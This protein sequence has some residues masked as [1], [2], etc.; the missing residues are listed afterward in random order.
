[1]EKLFPNICF[2]HA[3]ESAQLPIIERD[4]G[5]FHLRRDHG[6]LL[7]GCD[8]GAMIEVCTATDSEIVERSAHGEDDFDIMDEHT[9][10]LWFTGRAGFEVAWRIARAIARRKF[11]LVGMA[12]G[13]FGAITVNG[14]TVPGL[15]GMFS[16]HHIQSPRAA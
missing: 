12:P 9:S 7:P 3:H 16:A 15:T 6:W 8:L 11:E 5:F 13:E 1:M 14:E 10:R 2:Y 4:G